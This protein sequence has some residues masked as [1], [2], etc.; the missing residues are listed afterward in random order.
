MPSSE[1]EWQKTRRRADA[2]PGLSP[3]KGYGVSGEYTMWLPNPES[4]RIRRF[5]DGKPEIQVVGPM[6]DDEEINKLR[7]E[8]LDTFRVGIDN[9]LKY[10]LYVDVPL[11]N[12]SAALLNRVYVLNDEELTMLHSGDLWIKPIMIH[13][14]GGEKVMENWRRESF[15]SSG[16]AAPVDSGLLESGLNEPAAP[17]FPSEE[18]ESLDLSCD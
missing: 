14:V 5:V 1:Y 6:V 16:F 8:V 4:Q 9:D 2:P 7:Q 17:I 11:L 3:I 18:K 12:Y 13:V 10:R 15:Q